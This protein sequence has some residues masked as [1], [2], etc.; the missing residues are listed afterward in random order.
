MVLN[1]YLLHLFYLI[2]TELEAVKSDL[3]LCRLR[4][5]GPQPTLADSEA[6]TIALAGEF[7]RIDTDEG[8]FE[9]FRRYHLAEFPALA[10]VCRTTFVRQCA[11]LWN[12]TR[13]MLQR[14]LRRLQPL[15]A[16][17]MD[18]TIWWLIDSFPIRICRLSRAHRCK[19]FRGQ[20]GYGHDPAAWR[21]VYYGFRAHLRCADG[22]PCAAVEL[23]PA[24][25]PD[26]AV[27]A[28]LAPVPADP[29]KIEVELAD[30]GYSTS[31]RWAQNLA[32]LGTMLLA[33][34]KEPKKDQTPL[35]SSLISQLRQTIEIIIGQLAERFHAQRTWARDLWHLC[36]RLTRKVLSHSASVLINWMQGNMPLQLDRLLEN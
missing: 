5:R 34:T 18:G 31:P 30:R 17:P 6:I 20:A 13:L 15:L 28:E 8:I 3:G 10:K 16:D 26:G 2:D 36:A 7:L 19:L 32:R 24:N 1:D 25:V 9:Y 35:A 4:Q 22:G 27:A 23:T 11:N 12:M 33:P 29:L 21:D 14:V